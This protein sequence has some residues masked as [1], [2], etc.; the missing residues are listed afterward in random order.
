MGF[1]RL[2]LLEREIRVNEKHFLEDDDDASVES[3]SQEL[4]SGH[5]GRIMTPMLLDLVGRY[6]KGMEKD[7]SIAFLKWVPPEVLEKYL[8]LAVDYAA[9]KTW[10]DRNNGHSK[11]AE[12]PLSSPTRG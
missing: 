4:P 10:P 11:R 8:V 7:R 1:K 12:R 5:V 3:V 2:E 9:E 6:A